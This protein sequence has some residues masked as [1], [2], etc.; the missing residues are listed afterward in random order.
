[1]PYKFEDEGD[2]TTI[3]Q[4]DGTNYLTSIMLHAIA[5]ANRSDFD[6]TSPRNHEK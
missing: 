2:M 3:G 6:Q 4:I 5:H 1:M